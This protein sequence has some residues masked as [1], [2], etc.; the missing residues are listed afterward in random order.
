MIQLWAFF[1]NSPK[2]LKTYIKTAMRL[3]EFENLPRDEQRSVVKTVKKAVRTRWLSLDAGVEAA[4]K[5]YTYLLHALCEI[6]DEGATRGATADGIL[7]KLDNTTFLTVFYIL[8]FV[9]P[10]LS[11]LSK[12]FQAG[13]LNFSRISPAIEKTKFK[14]RKVVRNKTPLEELK[15]DLAGRHELCGKVLTDSQERFVQNVNEKYAKSIIK[16]IEERFPENSMAILKSLYIF[17]ID[18]FPAD[19]SSQQFLVHGLEEIDVLVEHYG[20]SE[21]V[22]EQWS[23]FRFEMQQLYRKWH[24]L[25]KNLERNN[26]KIKMTATEWTLRQILKNYA[27]VR[28][29]G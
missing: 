29:R 11:I 6:K 4:Y 24:D 13:E 22:H 18:N 5:E 2:R 26:L 23:D 25:K 28:N 21:R 10:H 3:K 12:T 15:K 17:N 1:K 16:N 20:N 14:I 19:A 7:K 8:K 9:L 27:D